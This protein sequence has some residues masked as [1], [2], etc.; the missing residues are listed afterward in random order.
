MLSPKYNFIFDGPK[1][2]LRLQD[3]EHTWLLDHQATKKGEYVFFPKHIEVKTGGMALDRFM[4]WELLIKAGQ[5]V[6]EVPY[7][8]GQTP[9]GNFFIPTPHA[10]FSPKTGCP[11]RVVMSDGTLVVTDVIM[12]GV[13]QSRPFFYKPYSG[14][15]I[16]PK[17]GS[18]SMKDGKL[19]MEMVQGGQQKDVITG[20]DDLDQN[21]VEFITGKMTIAESDELKAKCGGPQQVQVECFL[22]ASQA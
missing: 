22:V 6:P 8:T 2:S 1:S 20:I 18:A 11:F 5:N 13:V 19:N 7:I 14:N 12:H 15:L 10:A 21:R 3:E 16:L 17:A 4:D 9:G